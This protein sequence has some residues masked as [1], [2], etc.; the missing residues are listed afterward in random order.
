MSEH[1]DKLEEMIVVPETF[2]LLV[3]DYQ[4]TYSDRNS[5]QIVESKDIPQDTLIIDGPVFTFFHR[6]LVQHLMNFG[7]SISD[8]QP[9]KLWRSP[10]EFE[11]DEYFTLTV[12][13]R[14]PF[15]AICGDSFQPSAI[16]RVDEN[17]VLFFSKS[18]CDQ[19]EAATGLSFQRCPLFYLTPL[20]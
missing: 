4:I 5:Y 14:T 17:S 10:D 15:K 9:V 18:C 8:I 1:F 13:N 7:A 19:L 2:C 16:N 11:T 3:N 20:N 12:D 6:I